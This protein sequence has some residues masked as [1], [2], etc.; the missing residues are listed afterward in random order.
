MPG[1]SPG[2]T[3]AWCVRS[4]FQSGRRLVAEIRFDRAVHLD[5]QRVAVAVLGVA[6][7]DA[8]PALADAIFLDVGFLDALE[9]NADVAR[10]DIGIVIRAVRIDRQTVGEFVVHRFVG[11]A[12]SSASISLRS[13]S[14]VT[15]GA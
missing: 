10:E 5:R 3:G 12:H 11:L 15:V 14:G 4:A 9:T 2:M 1:T 13:P 8:H 6:G 7:G